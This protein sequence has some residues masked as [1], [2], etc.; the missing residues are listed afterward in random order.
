MATIFIYLIM[1]Y[2]GLGNLEYHQ[3]S[4]RDQFQGSSSE[5]RNHTTSSSEFGVV[6]NLWSQPDPPLC[7][8]WRGEQKKTSFREYR[9]F[10][11]ITVEE[12]RKWSHSWGDHQKDWTVLWERE[13]TEAQGMQGHY[14]A[15]HF[16]HQWAYEILDLVK[17]ANSNSAGRGW[18]LCYFSQNSDDYK[19]VG[20][21]TT[22]GVVVFLEPSWR[23]EP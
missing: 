14:P 3:Q 6:L 21:R 20:L 10:S 11:S 13:I 15:D 4:L 2:I 19:A 7:K 9:D 1:K 17:N 12:G 18:R 16:K 8:R 23:L 22:L 5:D